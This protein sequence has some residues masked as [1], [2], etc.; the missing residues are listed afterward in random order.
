[1]DGAQLALSNQQLALYRALTGV[2]EPPAGGRLAGRY[3]GA[4]AAIASAHNPDRL[5]QAGHSLREMMDLIPET[6][7]VRVEALREKLGNEAAK[8]EGAWEAA[9][10]SGCLSDGKWQGT[11]DR[12]LERF[13]LAAGLFYSWKEEHQ[14][15]RRTEFG[16]ILIELDA[17][18]KP[19][20]KVL[21]SL[22]VEAWIEM[23][24]YFV[25]I[26]HHRD[27]VDLAEFE[28]WLDA[29]ERTILNLLVPRTFEDFDKIDAI[30]EGEIDA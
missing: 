27:G 29:L 21:Q 20:P 5:A 12:P 8:L 23:H 28:G 26:A 10:K 19:A 18:K 6:V 9:Q 17:S 11:I 25:R 4:L 15:R 7:D 16:L 1:M 3:L 13:L 22:N 14:P 24:N 30:L 2:G